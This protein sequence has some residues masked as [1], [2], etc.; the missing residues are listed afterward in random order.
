MVTQAFS[1]SVR[2]IGFIGFQ[3]EDLSG[4]R[5]GRNFIR[6]AGEVFMRGTV[7]AVGYAKHPVFGDFPKPE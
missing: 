7:A 6:R 5:F 4:T 1:D 3:A 2:V